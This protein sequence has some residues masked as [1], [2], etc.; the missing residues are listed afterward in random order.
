MGEKWKGTREQGPPLGDPHYKSFSYINSKTRNKLHAKVMSSS[1]L[2]KGICALLFE[3]KKQIKRLKKIIP[4]KEQ[5]LIIQIHSP[6]K[7]Q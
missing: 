1:N 2:S 4:N 3:I 7:L 6:L 5:S